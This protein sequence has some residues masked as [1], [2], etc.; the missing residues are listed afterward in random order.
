ME[1]TAAILLRKMPWSETSLIVTWLTEDFG[2]VRTVARGARRPK[3]VFAGA[4]DLFYC[5][6][7]S[8]SVARKGDLHTL[9]DVSL[10]TVFNVSRAGNAGFYLASYFGELAGIAAP[11]MQPAH[12][13]FDLLKR[14]IN[15]VQD[16]PATVKAL[17][18]FETEL[19]RLLGVHDVSG[20][21]PAIDALVSLCGVIPASRSLALKFFP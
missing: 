9:R 13:I 5:A 12:G 15:F 14:G 18:H 21:V 4:L 10:T 6:D 11:S 17:N 1:Q 8:F 16:S 19:C 20:K 7:I 3:S 2:T